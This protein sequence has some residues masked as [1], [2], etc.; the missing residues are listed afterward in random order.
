[1]I[2]KKQNLIKLHTNPKNLLFKTLIMKAF[3]MGKSLYQKV[4]QNGTK[5]PLH[6][7]DLTCSL[8]NPE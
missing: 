4:N 5:T 3:S 1:M 2:G 6:E 7:S 8:Q